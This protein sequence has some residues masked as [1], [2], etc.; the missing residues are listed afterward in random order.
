MVTETQSES[1]PWRLLVIAVVIIASLL[2]AFFWVTAPAVNQGP[3]PPRHAPIDRLS[4][5]LWIHSGKSHR[6]ITRVCIKEAQSA[7]SVV[8]KAIA[9]GTASGAT[10]RARLFALRF[11]NAQYSPM[12]S[13]LSPTAQRRWGSRRAMIRFYSLKFAA[14]H[15]NSIGVG[16]ASPHGSVWTVPLSL[17]LVWRAAASRAREPRGL[18]SLFKNMPMTLTHDA[19]GWRVEEAGPLDLTAPIIP[20]IVLREGT[21]HIPIL[22]YHHVSSAPPLTRSQIDLTV[23]DADFT[24]QL[25]YLEMR[26]YHTIRL[27]DLFNALYYRVALPTRPVILSFDDGYLDN[28]TDAFPLLVR[29]H[30]VGEFN[31]ISLYPGTIIG[32][33]R[34]MT[35]GQI[36]AMASVGMEIESHT[37][38]HPDLGTLG[39][40]ALVYQLRFSRA[41]IA[42]HI[43]R[44][45]QFLAYP[46]GEPF[47]SGRLV[48]AYRVEGMVRATDYIGALLDP[49][50]PGVIERA[51]APFELTRIRVSH[52]ET[53]PVF[54]RRLLL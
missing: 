47:K 26:G 9:S 24:R 33:N 40:S 1:R 20:P 15:L 2:G 18:L 10:E 4:S 38:T 13:M 39:R 31:V 16:V 35:W 50:F 42:S 52:G 23:T 21:T 37:M 54:A 34:Y 27:T 49:L 22:M 25:S 6:S 29:H 17:N 32:V 46:A 8:P 19:S 44:A 30:M 41:I 36:E 51:A 45:V 28:Y 43:H 53:I 5:A 48:A 7:C 12:W 3:T 11:Q 14:T